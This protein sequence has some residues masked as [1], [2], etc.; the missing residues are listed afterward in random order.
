[1]GL[2]PPDFHAVA[3]VWLNGAWH[4]V[5]ATGLA[6]INGVVRVA[7]GRDATDISFL[8]IFGQAQMNCQQVSVARID[9]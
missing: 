8:T 5:D 4:L 1:L 9:A 7:V 2:E 3:E 6:P